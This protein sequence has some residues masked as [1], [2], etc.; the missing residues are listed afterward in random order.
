MALR[1]EQISGKIFSM[2]FHPLLV[3][4]YI[5]LFLT[6]VNPIGRLYVLLNFP[7]FAVILF[8]QMITTL[9]IP[10]VYLQYLKKQSIKV[11]N[12]EVLMFFLIINIIGFFFIRRLTLYMAHIP[13]LY[14][15][16]ITSLSSVML[17]LIDYITKINTY[18]AA[19]G[20]LTAVCLLLNHAINFSIISITLLVSG[21]VLSVYNAI[22]KSSLKQTLTGVIVGFVSVILCKIFI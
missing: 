4:T 8:T 15:F 2:L 6:F 7:L 21:L 10:L 11:T 14:S 5:L 3:P 16:I 1:W 20:I 22:G 13:Y 9:V 19:T 12:K 17:I 18:T